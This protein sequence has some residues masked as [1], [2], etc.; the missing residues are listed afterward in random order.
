LRRRLLLLLAVAALAGCS[1]TP[2]GA[3][4][5][6]PR[7]GHS[8]HPA[9]ATSP[10]NGSAG[11]SSPEFDIPD[12]PPAPAPVKITIPS[13]ST[14]YLHAIPTTQK[15]AFLTID[16]GFIKTPE[17]PRLIAAAHVPVTLFLTIDA[18]KDN[19]EYFRPMLQNGAVIE[20]HTITHSNLRGRSYAF[21]RHEICDGAD[22][23]GKLY[24]RRPVLFRPPFGNEDNITLK[25]AHDCGIKAAFMWKETVDK[26]IVRYQ[27]GH[28]VQPG[29]II[30]MHF[31]PAFQKDFL[32][33]L[34]A[35]H[36]AG[37]T[38]A[39]LDDYLP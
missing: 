10:G 12:F 17:A 32:A 13:G 39:L 9:S 23:L 6:S 30:L 26:G 27:Q 7:P 28:S 29:D 20:A 14:P 3:A 21:Q 25:A 24:T 22:Q 4:P 8:A 15:V 18:I 35:I 5:G 38:P 33:A 16:D 2:P 31:R 11:P 37:L 36:K 1:A 19:P 34:N